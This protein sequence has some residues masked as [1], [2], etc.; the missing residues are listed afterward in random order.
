ML[1]RPAVARRCPV[2]VTLDK[3]KIHTHTNTSS[4]SRRRVAYVRNNQ[5]NCLEQ[6]AVQRV[7]V[8]VS[9]GSLHVRAQCDDTSEALVQRRAQRGVGRSR[10]VTV[11]GK[12][13][14]DMKLH[15]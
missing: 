12:M 9:D 11:R 7:L 3:E 8:V 15:A 4:T 6:N 13:H 5:F 2:C 1:P 14:E 10:E